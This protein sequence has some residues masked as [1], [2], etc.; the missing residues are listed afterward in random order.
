MTISGRFCLRVKL[1]VL[2]AV[3]LVFTITA[4][5]DEFVNIP[6]GGTAVFPVPVYSKQTCEYA[7]DVEIK[8]LSAPAHADRGHGSRLCH[9][10]Q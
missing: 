9:R 2:T 3:L 1:L 6:S 4:F 8:V 7:T 5:A 10:Q